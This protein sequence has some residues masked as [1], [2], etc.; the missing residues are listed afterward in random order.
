MSALG[1]DF[2]TR[3]SIYLGPLAAL[4]VDPDPELQ[5]RHRRT[6]GRA[7]V[8]GKRRLDGGQMTLLSQASRTPELDSYGALVDPNPIPQMHAEP[9]KMQRLID[10]EHCRI[11][12][13][14]RS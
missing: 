6:R 1:P 2:E 13:F 7:M 9:T 11:N 12:L 14:D 8:H 4:R 10:Q 3:A 5:V